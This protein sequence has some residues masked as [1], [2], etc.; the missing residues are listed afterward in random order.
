MQQYLSLIKDVLV[1]G[2][3]KNDRTKIGIKSIFGRQMRFDLS[4]GYPLVTT[5]K[6]YIK[7]IIFELLWF[8]NGDTNIKFLQKNGV[9]IWNKWADK[10]GNLG[11][12]YGKQ[13]CSWNG[14]NG[15]TINQIEDLI[16]NINNNPNSRRLIVSAWNVSELSYMALM[17][18]HI[19]FQFYIY[20]NK[21]SCQLYQRSCDVF[22]GLPFNIASYSLLTLMIAQQCNL[23][24][25][26]FIWTGGDIH[27]Y[28]NHIQQAYTQISRT[29]Y[30][31]PKIK[32]LRKPKTIFEYQYE[33]FQ[34]INYQHHPPIKAPIAV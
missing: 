11:P 16:W 12:I 8:L 15:K 27:I 1:K 24:I 13:W 29:P 19:I 34:L 14:L 33:D 18:C 2:N 10:N 26:E 20:N 21:L 4:K 9:S 3:Y 23:E 17:P 31:L 25:G 30:T 5:K 22:L 32:I 7:S 6:C 28:N